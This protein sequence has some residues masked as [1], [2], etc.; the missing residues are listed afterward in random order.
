MPPAACA[1]PVMKRRRVTVSPSNE[2]GICASAV[3]LGFFGSLR[4]GDT[5]TEIY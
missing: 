2:P 1:V 3:V 5:G 4:S